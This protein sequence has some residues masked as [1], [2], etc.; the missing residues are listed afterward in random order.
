MLSRAQIVRWKMGYIRGF[1][2]GAVAGAVIGICIAPQPG[3]RTRAQ[4]SALGRAA[5]G[6]VDTAQRTAKH[7]A[8]VVSGAAAAAR[9]QV[10]RRR[11][12][13]DA[14]AAFRATTD[15]GHH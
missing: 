7:V 3:E 5:R 9:H 6:G 4:L 14:E 10:E 2:H 8:P 13:E 12:H 11:H 15:N 1:V